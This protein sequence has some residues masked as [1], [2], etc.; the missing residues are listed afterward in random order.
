MKPLKN[1]RKLQERQQQAYLRAVLWI[2]AKK[3]TALHTATH[4]LHAALAKV[5]KTSIKQLGSNITAERLRFDFNHD[6]PLTSDELKQ[7]EDM[8]N[9][10]IKRNVLGILIV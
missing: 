2:T 1:I 7:V 8:V 4:L 5:L 3:T 6:A 9:E 10:R